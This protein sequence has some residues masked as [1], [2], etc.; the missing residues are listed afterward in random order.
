MPQVLRDQARPAR[1]ADPH[2]GFRA[3]HGRSLLLQ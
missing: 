2:R 3:W 1:W